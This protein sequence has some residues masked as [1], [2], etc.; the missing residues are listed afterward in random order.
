M[1]SRMSVNKQTEVGQTRR[2]VRGGRPFL[3]SLLSGL[4]N[5]AWLFA[6]N[7]PTCLYPPCWPQMFPGR[8]WSPGLNSSCHFLLFPLLDSRLLC[9]PG[10]LS[11]VINMGLRRTHSTPDTISFEGYSTNMKL[12][13]RVGVYM[14]ENI[15]YVPSTFMCITAVISK[16]PHKV[17]LFFWFYRRENEVA[18]RLGEYLAHAFNDNCQN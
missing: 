16:P 12:Y 10:S 4:R 9:H 3:H 6:Q 14:R 18:K 13:S 15:Y 1:L 8:P 2:P 5:V 7:L 17:N 11:P